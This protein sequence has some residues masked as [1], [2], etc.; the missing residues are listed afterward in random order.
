MNKFGKRIQKF[1]GNVENCLVIGHGFGKLN[2]IAETFNTVFIFSE[3]EVP[4][5]AKNII[6]RES[7]DSIFQLSSISVIFFDRDQLDK[8]RPSIPLW[9]T[10]KPYIIIEGNDV[11]DRDQSKDLYER[12]YRAVELQGT[13]HIWR[14][15][16]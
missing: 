13:H 2:N 9:L 8:L 1:V 14:L 5:K 6:H 3:K 11:I 16:K 12:N 10:H 7:F 15:G 4:Y